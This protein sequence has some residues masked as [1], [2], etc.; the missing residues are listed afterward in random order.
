MADI[1]PGMAYL[2]TIVPAAVQ[3]VVDYFDETYVNGRV[4]NQQRQLA[5]QFPPELWSVHDETLNNYPRTNNYAE[6]WN[7]KYK[8]SVGQA[9]PIFWK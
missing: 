8:I 9:K 4:V 3:P 7:L 6:G 5:S 1:V 2:R